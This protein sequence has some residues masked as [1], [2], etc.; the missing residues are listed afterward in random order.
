MAVIESDVEVKGHLFRNFGDGFHQCWYPVAIASSLG[1][2]ERFGTDFCD[3]RIVVYRGQDGVAH[4]LS[5]YCPHMGADLSV[6]DVVGND[7]RCAFHHWQLGGDGVCTNIPSG[8]R[9]P[10]AACVVSFPLVEKHGLIWVFFGKTPTYDVPSFPES[11]TSRNVI[12]RPFE[13]PL[14]G[15]LTVEPWVFG[16]NLFDFVHFRVVHGIEGFDPEVETE[17]TTM[18]WTADLPHPTVG[19]MQVTAEMWGTNAALSYG[20]RGEAASAHIAGGTYMGSEGTK[21]FMTIGAEVNG[22]GDD[23]LRMAEES[24]DAQQ[25][26]HTTLINEDLPVMNSLRLGDDHL[27]GSD[28]KLAQYLRYARDYPRVTMASLGG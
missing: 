24:L 10:K 9:I 5:P 2:G 25:A 18:K 15:K 11:I 3:G 19:V 28:R 12:W 8:D 27:V 21:Y 17:G 16:T 22:N 20:A 26:L 7:I 13:V 1:K 14:S 6:G 4:A 23:A